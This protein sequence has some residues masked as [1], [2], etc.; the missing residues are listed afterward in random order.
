MIKKEE[1]IF[2]KGI[3][4][5]NY[6]ILAIL[7]SRFLILVPPFKFIIKKYLKNCENIYIIPGFR[8]FYGNIYAKNV[9][10]GDTFFMDYAPIYIG[11]N[12]KF[13]FENIVITATHDRADFSL[14][15]A[16]P[17]I[18]GKNVWITS[19]CVILGGVTIGDNSIIGAGSVVTKDIPANCFA[20][21]NP[22][23]VIS[24]FKDEDAKKARL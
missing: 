10:L 11:E 19:R 12:S 8:F 16:R 6:F 20:A 21:G 2:K 15:K 17:V 18:I 13:S 4:K 22:C 23:R 5:K 9:T 7:F 1:I 24:Y 14:V 3:P